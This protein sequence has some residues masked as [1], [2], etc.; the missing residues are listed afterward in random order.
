ME[1]ERLEPGID[2]LPIPDEWWEWIVNYRIWEANRKIFLYPENYLDPSIR[3]S[4]T[5]PFKNLENSLNQG[6]LDPEHI[7]TA[8]LNYL[9]EVSEVAHLVYVDAY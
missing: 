2:N 7:E 1:C 4:K 6:S 5:T 3:K 9:E 8:F